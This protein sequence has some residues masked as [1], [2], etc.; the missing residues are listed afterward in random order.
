MSYQMFESEKDYQQSAI[1][2]VA[3]AVYETACSV[4]SDGNIADISEQT[5]FQLLEIAQ[6]KKFDQ[7]TKNAIA[8]YANLVQ[9]ENQHMESMRR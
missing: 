5:L 9:E 8:M 6:V 1:A 3:L 2:Y 4:I 7:G